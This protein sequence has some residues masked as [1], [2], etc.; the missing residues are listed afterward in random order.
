[1][2]PLARNHA[3]DGFVA[4]RAEE[5][6]KLSNRAWIA[7]DPRPRSFTRP[8]CVRTIVAHT[9][10]VESVA[11]TRG[12]RIAVSAGGDNTVRVWDI[13]SGRCL[14][15]L[16][17]HTQPVYAVALSWDGA[18]A[19][20]GSTDGTLRVWDIISGNTMHVLPTGRFT[21]PKIGLTAD[22]QLAVSADNNQL[23]V[24]DLVSGT[25]VRT[26]QGRSDLVNQ[27]LDEAAAGW[28]Q[29]GGGATP[30]NITAVALTPDGK[31]AV[32]S[33]VADNSLT[34]LLRVW[35]VATGTCLR[36]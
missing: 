7:R 4:M 16:E 17:G 35:D 8:R 13:V 21:V 30:D 15:T 25:V 11:I 36:E 9:G 12:N 10:P 32:T 34:H 20:S 14:L 33:G 28:A 31:L 5:K 2:M 3:A 18:V 23:H 27:A 24:W 26:F 29:M 19:L 6:L 1:M 22:G